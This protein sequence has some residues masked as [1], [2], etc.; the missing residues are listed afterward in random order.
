MYYYGCNSGYAPY[1]GYGQG[2]GCGQGYGAGYGGAIVLV[3]FIILVS[4]IWARAFGTGPH[5]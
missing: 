1:A 2:C 5:N 3:L 4:I